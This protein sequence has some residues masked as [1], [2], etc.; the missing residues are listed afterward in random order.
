[1]RN[2]LYQRHTKYDPMAF[3]PDEE[4]ETVSAPVI[5][6]VHSSGEKAHHIAIL[7][8]IAVEKTT[9]FPPAGRG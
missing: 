8:C 6:T 1:M 4:E 3:I 9:K 2:L 7:P 5:E